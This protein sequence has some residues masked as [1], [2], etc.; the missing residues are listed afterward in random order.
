MGG[1]S[2]TAIFPGAGS[3]SSSVIF[4]SVGREG[5]AASP[6]LTGNIPAIHTRA[7]QPMH[8]TNMQFPPIYRVLGDPTHFAR[9]YVVSANNRHNPAWK[10]NPEDH[11]KAGKPSNPHGLLRLPKGVLQW[12]DRES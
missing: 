11:Y 3:V 2:S 8:R 6:P 9:H 4:P 12:D 10:C 7:V 1:H 5:G